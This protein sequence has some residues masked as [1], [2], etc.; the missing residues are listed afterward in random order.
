MRSGLARRSVVTAQGWQTTGPSIGP[1]DPFAETLESEII[2]GAYR[3]DSKVCGGSAGQA[4]SGW[5][6]RQAG[7]QAGCR[8]EMDP[9]LC[10]AAAVHAQPVCAAA[11]ATWAALKLTQGPDVCRA[12][13]VSPL[14]QHLWRNIVGGATRGAQQ[15]VLPAVP[16]A[17]PGV[18][19]HPQAEIGQLHGA[20]CGQDGWAGRQGGQASG[21]GGQVSWQPSRP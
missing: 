19:Q 14:C 20:I 8:Q 3:I 15:R 5:V 12:P 10:P 4:A 1:G 2:K 13:D 17:V 7:R 6:C 18:W 9:K 16:A 21:Q 11:A